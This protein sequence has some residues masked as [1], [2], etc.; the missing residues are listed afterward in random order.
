MRATGRGTLLF[1]TGSA[2]LTPRPERASSG[3]VNAAQSTYFRMLHDQLAGEGIYA[4]HA[5]IVGAIGDGGHDPTTIAQPCGTP[6]G[7]ALSPR[8]S[9][10]SA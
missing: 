2:A 6:R 1:T 7:G 9:S 5:V 3:I 8:S 4:L 10:D